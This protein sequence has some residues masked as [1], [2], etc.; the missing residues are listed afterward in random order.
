MSNYDLLIRGGQVYDSMQGLL[1]PADVAVKGGTIVAIGPNLGGS[2][3][4]VIDAHGHMVCPGLIDMHTHLGFELHTHVIDAD[5]FCPAA[6]VTTAVDMGSAGAFTLAWYRE[7]AVNRSKTRLYEFINI[8]SLGTIAIHTPYYVDNYGKY[9]DEFETAR[10]ID[11]NRDLVRGIKVFMAGSMTGEWALPA[12]RA[13]RR[14]ADRTGVPIAVHIS[15][16]EPQLPPILEL[17]GK[18]DIVT[19]CFTGHGQKIIDNAGRLLPEVLQARARG[20]RFDIGHGAGS[21]SFAT[22]RAALAQGFL[23]DSISTDLYHANIDGPVWDLPTT[24]SKLLA[25]GMPLEQVLRAATWAPAVNLQQ[26]DL[27]YLR[28]GGMA[29]IC[30]LTL[31]EG[32]FTLADVAGEQ[33]SCRQRLRNDL[34]IRNGQI[35]YTRGA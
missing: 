16:P 26:P 25:L 9:V 1:Q 27:G 3:E 20:V 35:L 31:E 12:L 18:G 30:M 24:L 21:F 28:V 8:A 33:V 7:R 4:R 19:H 6:G 2:A 23:P 32:N 10:L 17:L 34:T 15:D 5:D 29:D 11:A 13:A 22:A 14:V